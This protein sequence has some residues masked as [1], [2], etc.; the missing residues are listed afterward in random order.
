M[1]TVVWMVVN[2]VEMEAGSSGSLMREVVK[3]PC[4]ATA[5][6]AATRARRESL[7]GIVGGSAGG[8]VSGE[9][10]S[11]GRK[12]AARTRIGHA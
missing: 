8:G 10:A 7:V 9:K 11:V 6:P 1:V 5:E 4:A 2:L 3:G 12:A